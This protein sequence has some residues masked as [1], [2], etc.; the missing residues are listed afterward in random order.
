MIQIEMITCD[1]ASPVDSVEQATHRCFVT[2]DNEVVG[3]MDLSVSQTHG[4][5]LET[6]IRPQDLEYLDGLVKTAMHQLHWKGI[7][8]CSYLLK[9]AE[10]VRYFSRFQV[11]CKNDGE[12]CRFDLE[13]FIEAA[14]CKHG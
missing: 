5:V 10:L 12:E 1:G 7:R 9:D 8:T 14:R 4:R 3:T 11:P 2:L 6:R 13:D